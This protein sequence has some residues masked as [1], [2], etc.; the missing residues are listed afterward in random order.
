MTATIIATCAPQVL[1]YFL[2]PKCNIIFN[3]DLLIRN[4]N[5]KI[6]SNYFN[7]AS[8]EN[9]NVHIVKFFDLN[10]F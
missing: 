8:I 3:I 1:S 6:K 9:V 2:S 7:L 5:F 4:I 10:S